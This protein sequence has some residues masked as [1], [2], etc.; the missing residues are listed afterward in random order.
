VEHRTTADLERELDRI[1]ASP[2]GS[3]R[4]ELIVRRP[5][6]SAR[7]VLDIAELDPAVGLVGDNWSTR[8]S[9]ETTDRSAHPL[10]QLNIMNARAAA[11]IAGGV[12]DWPP[13]GDQL[14]VDLHLGGA[15]LPP[16]TRLHVGDAVIEITELAHTGCA[17]FTARFGQ[18]AMRFVNSPIGRALNLRGVCA[19]VLVGGTIRTGDVVSVV[20]PEQ[21]AVPT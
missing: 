12:E 19:R 20:V 9:R 16:G 1:Q 13:A 8:G 21:A 10:R 4:L 5:S 17:K 18:D 15:V 7:E 3:G 11:A 6:T 14:Y 2:I